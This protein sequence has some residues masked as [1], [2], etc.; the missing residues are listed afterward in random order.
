MHSHMTD[1]FSIIHCTCAQRHWTWAL[2]LKAYIACLAWPQFICD[3][4]LKQGWQ[5]LNYTKANGEVN[6]RLQH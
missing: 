4:K 3:T 5:N 2:S 1:S 6:N